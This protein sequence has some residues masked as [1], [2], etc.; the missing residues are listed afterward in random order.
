MNYNEQC[1]IIIDLQ[2]EKY[3]NIEKEQSKILKNKLLLNENPKIKCEIT[4]GE[5]ICLTETKFLNN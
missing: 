2:K 1:Q 4:K 3:P 5:K